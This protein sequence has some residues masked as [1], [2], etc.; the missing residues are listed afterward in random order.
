MVVVARCFES[1]LVVFPDV[2]RSA[3]RASL[4]VDTSIS[5]VNDKRF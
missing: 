2:T 3:A 1:N 4:G 5:V